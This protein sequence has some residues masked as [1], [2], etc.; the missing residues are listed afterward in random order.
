MGSILVF[1]IPVVNTDVMMGGCEMIGVV[2]GLEYT[3]FKPKEGLP[4]D[5]PLDPLL[6]AFSMAN[7]PIAGCVGGSEGAEISK[8][9][10]Q[11]GF[12]SKEP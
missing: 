10:V 12:E 9:S 7:Y 5:G 11:T 2:F 3:F 4:L 8:E 1:S 6:F